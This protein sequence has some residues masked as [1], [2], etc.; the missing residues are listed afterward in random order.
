MENE[1]IPLISVVILSLLLFGLGV[2]FLFFSTRF[3]NWYE[4]L[5]HER[6]KEKPSIF[7]KFSSNLIKQ[8]WYIINLKIG[9][10]FCILFAILLFVLSVYR[11]LFPDRFR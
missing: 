7:Y 10:L 1:K 2:V 3:R 9:G 4:N 8:K 6:N 5:L 11:L